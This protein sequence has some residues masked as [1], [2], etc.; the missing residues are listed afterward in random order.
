M[1]IMSL[2]SFLLRYLLVSSEFLIMIQQM[3]SNVSSFTGCLKFVP[4]SS[5]PPLERFDVCHP[6][7]PIYLFFSS[8][9][10]MP[11][12]SYCIAFACCT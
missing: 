8:L 1:L 2:W 5:I 12:G 4:K 10:V 6:R 3:I 7:H 9:G 11:R